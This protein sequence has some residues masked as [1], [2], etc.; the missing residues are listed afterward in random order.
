MT[1][2][3][4]SSLL[5]QPSIFTIF[6]KISIV[7]GLY[8]IAFCSLV[9]A[10]ISPWF[11]RWGLFVV[12]AISLMANRVF[13]ELTSHALSYVDWVGLWRARANTMDA[14]NQYGAVF[15]W[16]SAALL[17]VAFAFW[18]MPV[19]PIKRLWF[20]LVYTVSILAFVTICVI[21]QGVGTRNLPA[22]SSLYGMM[23]ASLFDNPNKPYHYY[24]EHLPTHSPFADH[25]LL[26]VDESI[27]YD[28]FNQVVM[29]QLVNN[30]EWFIYDFGMASSMANCSAGSNIMLRKSVRLNDI[31]DDLYQRPL[32][33]SFARNAGFSTTL[34]DA[35]LSGENHNYFD[36]QELSMID[37]RPQL[38]LLEDRELVAVMQNA[39]QAKRSFSYIIKSGAHFT[40]QD[41][42]PGTFKSLSSALKHPYVQAHPVRQH[43]VHAIDYQTGRFFETLL[44]SQFPPR[45]LIFYT[46]DHG[47]NVEDS[48]GFTHCTYSTEPE[49]DEGVVPLLVLSN[50]AL[51]DFDAA[52]VGN[53]HQLSHADLMG[54]ILNVMGYGEMSESGLLKTVGYNQSFVYGSP[55]GHFNG[56]V[57]LKQLDGKAYLAKLKARWQE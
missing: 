13:Y 38:A 15:L 57:K 9:L 12:L 29:Q 30:E 53:Q 4:G 45:T 33:W 26:V 44:E 52:V 10:A 43:Y 18:I 36:Q 22:T 50:L 25:V 6:V 37:Q 17:P 21:Q 11:L 3:T 34:L 54:T 16:Q 46:A 23:I 41:K 28:F 40:Y 39:T 24:G 31:A 5:H 56:A 20:S 42:Y 55:F 7:I 48:K 8:V 27:R 35:Q 32:I 47:Q 14:I 49:E 51:P 2:I 19:L 1:V